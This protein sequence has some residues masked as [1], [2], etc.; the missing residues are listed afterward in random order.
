L[1]QIVG[2]SLGGGTASLLTYILREQKEFAS[3]TCFTFAP[4]ACM[5]WDLAESGKH[6]ITT[7]INGSDLVPTFSASSVDDLRSEVY[8]LLCLYVKLHSQDLSLPPLGEI[9]LIL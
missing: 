5:T 7:I 4:A 8:D 9:F 3:A 6:F 2:H 1:F